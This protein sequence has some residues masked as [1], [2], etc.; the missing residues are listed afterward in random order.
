MRSAALVTVIA[1]ALVAAGC[2]TNQTGQASPTSGQ[3]AASSAPSSTAS[4]SGLDSVQACSLVTS[5]EAQQIAPV[6][7][8]QE[9]STGQLG[10][11]SS[12]CGWNAIGNSTAGF[13]VDIRPAQ[14][15]AEVNVKGGTATS[16]TT[17]LGHKA[18]VVRN[19]EGSGSCVVVVAIGSGRVDFVGTSFNDTEGACTVA[20]KLA[21]IVEP[22]LP[23][24]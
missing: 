20:K 9:P 2:T 21:D 15:L 18:M 17:T 4:A 3:P 8:P 23:A 24:S 1:A 22:K 11:A 12:A 14:T 16:A 19:S 5:A 10:G 7:N 13:E 6:G